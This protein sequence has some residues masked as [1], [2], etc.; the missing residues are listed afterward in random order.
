[1][2]YPMRLKAAREAIDTELNRTN[3]RLSILIAEWVEHEPAQ[4]DEDDTLR[5]VLQHISNAKAE[6]K[7]AGYALEEG[8]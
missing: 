4:D 6:L 3:Q 5:A 2:S 1:M 8:S 7:R